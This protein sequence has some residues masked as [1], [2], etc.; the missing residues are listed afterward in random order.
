M[1]LGTETVYPALYKDVHAVGV[2][3]EVFWF[4]TACDL[5]GRDRRCGE[6]YCFQFQS[7]S[8]TLYSLAKNKRCHIC[9][10]I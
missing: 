7:Q 1:S 2:H 5:V 8:A 6:I 4:V 9:K 10:I 3:N